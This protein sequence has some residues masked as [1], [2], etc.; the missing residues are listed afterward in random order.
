MARTVAHARLETR[1]SRAKLS[2]DK[3]A[4]WQALGPE[5]QRSP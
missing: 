1:S 3:K 4:H 2:T 5:P